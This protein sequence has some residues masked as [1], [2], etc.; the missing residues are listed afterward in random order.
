MREPVVGVAKRLLYALVLPLAAGTAFSDST[1]ARLEERQLALDE[2][3]F[4]PIGG[5]PQWVTIKGE[6]AQN[7]VL[8]VLHGGPGASFSPYDDAVF[9]AWRRH[10]IVVQWD[11]RG[12]GRTYTNS[13]PSID[14]TMTLDRMVNDGIEVSEFLEGRL[15][16]RRIALFGGSWGSALGVYMM[17]KRPDLFCAYVGTAQIVSVQDSFMVAYERVRA[18]AKAGRDSDAV[19][20]LTA[21]GPPPWS[22]FMTMMTFIRWVGTYEARHATPLNMSLSAEYASPEEREAWATA[23]AFSV[24]HFFGNDLS[25]PLMHIDLPAL[26]PDFQQPVFIIQGKDDLR[27]PPEL[28][29]QYFKSIRAP[30][31]GFFIVPRTAHEPS[32]ASMRVISR[33]LLK[34]AK[35]ACSVRPVNVAAED[36]AARN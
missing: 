10:F 31:K 8:L 4:V 19:K 34:Q 26:G 23:M 1:N 9:G 3:M 6:D 25:G 33:V 12:A 2:E 11:Q 14:P 18:M 7:P 17:K 20:D 27:A 15:N 22:S 29:R 16:T 28:A 24:R 5:I 21:I 32:A 35:P 30:R 13:G 36:A